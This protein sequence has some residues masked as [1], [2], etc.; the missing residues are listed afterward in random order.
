[1]DHAAARRAARAR[2]LDL[3]T[4]LRILARGLASGL[5]PAAACRQAQYV[6]VD[7]RP[8]PIGAGLGQVARVA[9]G[10][11]YTAQPPARATVELPSLQE[12]APPRPVTV[13]V[14]VRPGPSAAQ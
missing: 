10:V 4:D 5:G 9:A 2:G 14:E 1:M 11:G 7:H 3:F 13:R 6:L 12:P 8:W